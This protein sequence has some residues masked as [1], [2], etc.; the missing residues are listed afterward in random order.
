MIYTPFQFFTSFKF[1]WMYIVYGLTYIANNLSDT[2]RYIPSVPVEIQNLLVTFLVNTSVGVM[3]DKAYAQHFGASQKRP[4][5][6]VSLGLFYTR[7][8][9]TVASAF[10]LPPLI[11]KSFSFSERKSDT[12]AQLL[13]PLLIQMVVSPLHLLGLDIYNRQGESWQSRGRKIV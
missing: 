9:I 7:D 4:F 5:P 1:R 11:E 2:H 10:T 13:C 12:I 3:K 6:Y 8:I